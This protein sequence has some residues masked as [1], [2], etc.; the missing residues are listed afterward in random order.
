M[1]VLVSLFMLEVGGKR[2][3]SKKNWPKRQTNILNLSKLGQL[4]RYI[5]NYPVMYT[6]SISLSIYTQVYRVPGTCL[7]S[8]RNFFYK[9]IFVVVLL[10]VLH[11]HLYLL[12]LIVAWKYSTTNSVNSRSCS[13]LPASS[14]CHGHVYTPDS[15]KYCHERLKIKLNLVLRR[16]CLRRI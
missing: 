1:R 13:S 10:P 9:I 14:M 11:V 6:I 2:M 15:C 3:V 12:Q 5:V 4:D 8:K 7:F 16:Y